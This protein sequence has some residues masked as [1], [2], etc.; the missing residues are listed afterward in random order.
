MCCHPL[1]DLCIECLYTIFKPDLEDGC[2]KAEKCTIGENYCI[3]FNTA[4]NFCSYCEI[5]LFADTDG[6]Y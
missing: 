2:I 5:G 6:D 4:G 3:E 1:T